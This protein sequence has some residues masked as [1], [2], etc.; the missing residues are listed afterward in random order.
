[1][2]GNPPAPCEKARPLKLVEL[3]PVG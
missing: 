1:V 3:R 2:L